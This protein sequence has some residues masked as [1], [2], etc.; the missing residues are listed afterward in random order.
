[1]LSI[2]HEVFI[3]VANHL[4]FSKAAEILFIS[5]PAISK[6]IKTLEQHYKTTLFDRSGNSIVL[7]NAG[8]LLYNHL[9]KAKAI[10]KQLEFD[11]STINSQLKAKGQKTGSQHNRCTLYYSQ[12]IVV[13]PS[14]ISG[15]K[16]QFIE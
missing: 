1:M 14:K 11:I 2:R 8:K 15:C 12:S 9:L 16:N 5:Q 6:H 10:Q 7:T 3:E 13:F 4:S